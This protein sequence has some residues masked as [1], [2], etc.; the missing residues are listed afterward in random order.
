LLPLHPL[1]AANRTFCPRYAPFHSQGILPAYSQALASN[2]DPQNMLNAICL[3]IASQMFLIITVNLAWYALYELEA[4]MQMAQPKVLLHPPA[5]KPYG[6]K[7]NI[8]F[9]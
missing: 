3:P 5:W 2:F 8:S 1:I 4:M 6:L 7:A 9:L